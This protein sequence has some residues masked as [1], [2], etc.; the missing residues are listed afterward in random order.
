M[1]YIQPLLLL[2]G[3]IAI[4]S[5]SALRSSRAKYIALCGVLGLLLLSWPPV[6]WLLALPLTAR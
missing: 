5:V 2:C 3:A 1:T 4:I 6:D